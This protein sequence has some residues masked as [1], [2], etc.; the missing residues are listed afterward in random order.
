MQSPLVVFIPERERG[1]LRSSGVLPPSWYEMCGRALWN[2]AG[3]RVYLWPHALDYENVSAAGGVPP[4]PAQL[5]G[6]ETKGDEGLRSENL[7][8]KLFGATVLHVLFLDDAVEGTPGLAD[9]APLLKLL[10]W[11]RLFGESVRAWFADT[12]NR[13]IRHVAVVV[14]RTGAF[15]LSEEQLKAFSDDFKDDGVVR[16]CYLVNARLE[17]GLGHDALHATYLWPVIVGRLILRILIEL[18]MENPS[19]GIFLPGVHLIRSFEYLIECPDAEAEGLKKETQDAVYQVIHETPEVAV[20]EDGQSRRPQ[21][22]NREIGVFPGLPESLSSYARQQPDKKAVDWYREDIAELVARV[23]DDARWIEARDRARTD[24]AARERKQFLEKE[25]DRVMEAREI[26]CRVA[27]DPGNIT[28]EERSLKDKL[29]SDTYSKDVI[30]EKWQAMV[31]AEQARKKAQRDLETA[32][33][34]MVRA[35]NHYVTAPYGIM[36]VVATSIFCGFAL[37]RLLWSIAGNGSLLVA[38]VLSALS[39]VGAVFAWLTVSWFHRRA[40]I[41]AM[42]ELRGLAEKV[43]ATM[44]LRHAAA[45]KVVRAAEAR[46]NVGLRRGAIAV[47]QRLLARVGRIVGHELQSPT[48]GAFYQKPEEAGAVVST[49]G[50]SAD[51]EGR[52]E[53]LAVFGARTRFSHELTC[54]VSDI[55][56]HNRSPHV[57]KVIVEAFRERGEKSFRAFWERLCAETDGLNQQGNYPAQIFVP[58]IREWFRS[59]GGRLV[60]AQKLDLVASAESGP[61]GAQTAA[62]PAAFADL[63]SDSGYALASADVEDGAVKEAPRIVFVPKAAA[64]SDQARTQL[65]GGGGGAI[66]VRETAVLDSLPQAAFFFQD[67]RVN[68][69]TRDADGRL[70]FLSRNGTPVRSRSESGVA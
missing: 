59:F 6:L 13:N 20:V 68:G 35:Q 49:P 10:R 54:R 5:L 58:R 1:A 52:R 23:N 66:D 56:G 57:E 44:D 8:A 19:G 62:L 46:H 50:Q 27:K 7:V 21:I 41:M 29:P 55:N 34:E 51:G 15:H 28:R 2:G 42:G 9:T 17:V 14:A 24:F 45:V 40:G 26:F 64:L 3:D 16:T 33:G 18:S 67:I 69:I 60:M 48:P 4:P 39:M 47:L 37:V 12:Q 36:A 61:L 70:L 25:P 53:E 63:R 22:V 43:D 32:G 11:V 30:Y 38:I 65:A 31:Q